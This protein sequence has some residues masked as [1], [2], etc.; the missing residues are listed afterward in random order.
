M[1]KDY[2]RRRLFSLCCGLIL[3]LVLLTKPPSASAFT[4]TQATNMWNAYNNAFYVGNNG[5][6]YYR[7]D[8]GGGEDTVDFWQNA[9]RIEMAVDR[10]QNSGSAGDKAIVTALVNGFDSMYGSDWTGDTFNDDIMWAC[11]AHLRAYF[12][13]GSTETG[14]AGEAANN[15]NWVCS[16]GHSPGRVQPQIDSVYGGGMWWT[17]DHTSS[18][19]SKNACDNGPAALVGY[20]LSVVWPNTGFKGTAQGIYNWEK[21]TLLASNGYLYD[22]INSSGLSGYDLSYQAGTFIGAAYLLGDSTTA[23]FEASYFLYTQCGST[24][25]DYGILD[26][27]GTGSSGNAGFN[28]IFLRWMAVYMNGA[29]M[30]ATYLPWLY[31]NAAAAVTEENSSDLSWSDWVAPTPG[32][33]LYSWDCTPAITALNVVPPNPSSISSGMHTLTPGNAPG[34]R[35][36]DSAG[37]TTNGN[38]IQIWTTAG[39]ANQNWNFTNIGG[40]TWNIAV[41]LGP[42]C[43]DGA[44]ATVGAPTHLWS[45]VGVA[46]QAWTAQPAAQSG[47]WNFVS[48]LSG[49][50]LDVTQAG[51]GNGTVVDSYTCNQTEAQAWFVY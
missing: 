29:G 22:H 26:N 20:Y 24:N 40:N 37:G 21:S 50:C 43:L 9:E 3:A 2:S 27:Y 44:A 42:Y 16:G 39:N 23:N 38:T 45:C 28:S 7:Q 46:D 49:L 4:S 48:Q 34:S 51:T 11:L 31:V 5:A 12:V 36:D 35:L 33:G 32:S 13:T 19:A 10:A 6:A 1:V 47:A 17:T 8:Q 30:Q 14:W 15:Y 18:N 41:S 25:A